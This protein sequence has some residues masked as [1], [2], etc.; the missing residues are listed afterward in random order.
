MS[1]T[2]ETRNLRQCLGT[3]AV[4]QFLP[5][6]IVL[7]MQ[8]ITRLHAQGQVSQNL[9]MDGRGAYEAHS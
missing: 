1:R 4:N 7:Y 5:D 3:L 2:G 9:G 8:E 6:M